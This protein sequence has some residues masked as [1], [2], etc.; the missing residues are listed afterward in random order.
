MD[1]EN[2]LRQFGLT[3]IEIRVYLAVLRLGTSSVSEVA[4]KAGTYRTYTYEVLKSLKE[5]GLVGYVI[6][7]GRQY[8]Q[9]TKPDSILDI[10]KEKEA[11]IQEII[12]DLNLAYKSVAEKPRILVFEGKDGIKSILNSIISEKPKEL[13]QLSSTD[14]IQ[15]LQFYFPNWVRH[16]VE[17]GISTRILNK[18]N[19]IMEEYRKKGK[20]ELRE[21]RFLSDNFKINTTTFIYN[22]KVA[23]MVAKE[24]NLVGLL[25]ESKEI[26]ETQRSVFELIW[27]STPE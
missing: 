24:N 23:I 3:D 9:A 13:L 7:S 18:R 12:P 19:T 27:Q 2:A 5:K 17:T 14:I 15:T 4:N 1:C 25:I 26:V 8:F 16:R 21:V 20:K 10:L 22:N 11:I 6:K